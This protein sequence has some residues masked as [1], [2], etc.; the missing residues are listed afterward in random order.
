MI[1]VVIADDEKAVS[2]IIQHFIEREKLPLQVEGIALDGE[3]ALQMIRKKEP[4]L[5]FLDIKMPLMDGFEVMEALEALQM[6]VKIVVITA[7]ES[8]EYAQR[9]LRMGARDIIL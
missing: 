8:F 7:Y 4:D 3:S 1:K 6:D 9:A 2:K 5:V